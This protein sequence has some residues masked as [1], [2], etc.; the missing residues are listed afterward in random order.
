MLLIFGMLLVLIFGFLLS[1]I[2][3][4]EMH[5]ME[6]LGISY[7]LGFGIFTLLMFCY[8][9]LGIKITL[10]STLTALGICITA[11]LAFFKVFKRKISINLSGFIK[12]L[13]YLSRLEKIIVSVIAGLVV[14][15]FTISIYF[16]VYIWDALAL[17][18]FR[19]KIIAQIGFYTQIANNY[20]W[21][22]GY[23]LFTS[24]SHTLVYI[25]GG[26]NPQFLYSSMYVSYIFV[27]YGALR[28]IVNRKVSLISTLL[29]ATTPVFFDHSTFAYTN[30]PYS[31]FLSMGSIYIYVWLVKNKPFGYLIL[32][33]VMTGLSTWTRS[34][35][36]FWIINLIVLAI[37]LLYKIKKYLL[38]LVVYL[39]TFLLIREPW[40]IVNNY[41]LTDRKALIASNIEPVTSSY[42]SII[43]RIPEWNRIVEIGVYIY[44]YI[45]VSWYPFLF[46]FLLCLLLSVKNFFHRYGSF[47]VLIIILYFCLLVFGTYLFTFSNVSWNEIPDSARRM[48]MFFMPLMIFYAGMVFDTFSSS[49]NFKKTRKIK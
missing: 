47:F 11:T 28:Q 26:N 36:P 30:L 12:S 34:T 44:K 21:F 24:L 39:S 9:T 3:V 2:L 41:I 20:V 8:S 15:S 46:L 48:S 22:G 29:L 49:T 10:I 17:Y 4:E 38:P 13:F 25:F 7:L 37:L 40:N 23:P 6:R 27:F 43:S 45:V 42:I 16:P 18:D 5:P 32:A 33:A 35:E 14:A 19:A 1:V 31:I